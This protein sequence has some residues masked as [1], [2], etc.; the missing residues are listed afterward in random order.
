MLALDRFPSLSPQPETQPI[1]R[2]GR[3]LVYALGAVV[4]LFV[5]S[6]LTD[7]WFATWKK[8]PGTGRLVWLAQLLIV[9]SPIAALLLWRQQGLETCLLRGQKLSYKLLLGLFLGVLAS[10]VFLGV[11]GTLTDYSRYLATLGK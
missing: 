2:P 11:R 8:I 3:E 4:L 6:Q 10:L 9:Y 7:A 5:M 1:R